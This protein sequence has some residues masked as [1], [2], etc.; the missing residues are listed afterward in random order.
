MGCAATS[1]SRAAALARVR[2]VE[3]VFSSFSFVAMR[4]LA[5]R[6]CT[7]YELS[8]IADARLC[9]C[10]IKGGTRGLGEDVFWELGKLTAGGILMIENAWVSAKCWI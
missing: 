10:C 1:T 6:P 8:G 2:R 5:V 4:D 3:F 9:N 7:N